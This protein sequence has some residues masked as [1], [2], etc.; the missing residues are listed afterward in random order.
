MI[1][2]L[3]TVLPSEISDEDKSII[4]ECSHVFVVVDPTSPCGEPI[5]KDL[6]RYFRAIE[7]AK[8]C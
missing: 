1:Q 5:E 6:L 7:E 8:D 2:T 4:E 3:P